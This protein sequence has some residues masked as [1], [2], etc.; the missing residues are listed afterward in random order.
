MDLGQ[1]GQ[2]KLMRFDIDSQQLLQEFEFD[3][4]IAP[5]KGNLNDFVLSKDENFAFIADVGLFNQKPS[6]IT[7]NLVTGKATNSFINHESTRVRPTPDG[8]K[9]AGRQVTVPFPLGVD[10]IAISRDGGVVYFAA[11]FDKFMWMV[12]T[13]ALVLNTDAESFVDVAFP[14]PVSDGVSGTS[15]SIHSSQAESF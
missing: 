9:I 13:R 7:L 14:K 5:V 12:P 6:L 1:Q 10:S 11:V 4:K 8:F 15:S 2:P 3:P